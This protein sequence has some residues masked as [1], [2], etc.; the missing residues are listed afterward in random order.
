MS[1]SH[2]VLDAR[3]KINLALDVLH[4]R[5]DGYHEVAM[6]M[7][8]VTLADR[9]VIEPAA[10]ISVTADMADLECGPDNLAY[11]AAALLRRHTGGSRGARIHLQKS[12]PLA[13]GLAGGSADAAAVLRGLNTLWQLGLTASELE[14]L[15]VALGSDVPF[16][17]RGGTA[18]A[19]GRGEILTPLPAPPPLWIVLAKPRVAV[20]TAWVYG[21]YRGELVAV[22]PDIAGMTAS[23]ARG[24]LPGLAARL[25]NVLETV[26]VA[27]HPEIAALKAAMIEHG[28]MA[29]LMSGSGP[30][31]FGLT[32]SRQQ[33]QA[34]AAA[35]KR[36]SAVWVAVTQ[37]AGEWRGNDGTPLTTDQA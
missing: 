22:H 8:S 34:I 4:K 9:V 5:P 7:Q 35:L 15:G 36:A 3:A 17:L 11:R 14:T 10:E 31:V 32:E 23:L 6:V 33:A 24:D 37:T 21:N 25:A 1:D 16:C 29:S 30:T 12:I 2:L 13:A 28:A 26:T 27:A 20:S 18:L 19:T